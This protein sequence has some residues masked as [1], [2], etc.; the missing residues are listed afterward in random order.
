[1]SINYVHIMYK[2]CIKSTVHYNKKE[3]KYNEILS[4]K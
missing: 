1:M 2:K 3:K 4:N